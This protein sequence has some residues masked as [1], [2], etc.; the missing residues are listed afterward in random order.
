MHLSCIP[1]LHISFQISTNAGQ[2]VTTCACLWMYISYYYKLSLVFRAVHPEPHLYSTQIARM[3]RSW[4]IITTFA[5]P[6]DVQSILSYS[7]PEFHTNT[8]ISPKHLFLVYRKLGLTLRFPEMNS[9]WIS[10][11]TLVLQSYS[12][13]SYAPFLM[14]RLVHLSNTSFILYINVDSLHQPLLDCIQ[15]VTNFSCSACG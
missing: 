6:A 2:V 1:L 7:F 9:A 5:Q 14:F 10:T 4:S 11:N 12:S 8:F 3:Q 13:Y 15:M